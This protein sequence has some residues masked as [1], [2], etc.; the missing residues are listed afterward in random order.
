M[1][2]QAPRE[3]PSPPTSAG[4]ARDTGGGGPRAGGDTPSRQSGKGSLCGGGEPDYQTVPKPAGTPTPGD[5][6]APPARLQPHRVRHLLNGGPSAEATADSTS[7]PRRAGATPNAHAPSPRRPP[8]SPPRPP[9]SP[10]PD[11]SS[12]PTP[13]SPAPLSPPAQPLGPTLENIRRPGEMEPPAAP[14]LPSSRCLEQV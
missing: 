4:A 7:W 10:R 11:P 5:A 1:N 2:P 13:R 12:L 6:G 3:P 14:S 9:S 8:A